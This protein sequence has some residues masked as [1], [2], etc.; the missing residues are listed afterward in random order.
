MREMPD[1]HRFSAGERLMNRYRILGELGR[2]GMGVVYKCLDEIGG[3]EVALKA[4]PLELG[5]NAAE[6]EEVREN[7]QLVSRLVHQHIAAIKTLE[8][9][10][11]S[12]DYYLILE[13]AEGAD[14]RRWRKQQGG[15]PS[16]D[17]SIP[18]LRQV[19]QALDYAH[20]LKIIHRDVKPGNVMITP[21]GVV[22]VLDFG[23]AAQIQSSMA[24]VSRVHFSTSGTGPY[25]SPEQW[26]G[27][28]QDGASD[29]Y[30]LAVMAFELLAG[31]LPFE[32]Q[33]QF[34]LRESAIRETP[35]RPEG[36]SDQVWLA[37]A[38][39]L[40]KNST[41]RFTSCV[42]FVAALESG[43]AES[44]LTA[45]SRLVPGQWRTPAFYLPAGIV[46]VLLLLAG[47]WI[48]K[49]DRPPKNPVVALMPAKPV[50]SGAAAAA[51]EEKTRAEAQVKAREA[52]ARD[53]AEAEARAR[54]ADAQAKTEAE[55]NAR[56]R[57]AVEKLQAEADARARAEARAR[58]EAIAQA[59]AVGRLVVVTDPDG[60][61]VALGSGEK[62]ES[63]A[64]FE[65]LP[66]GKIALNISKDGYEP[67]T[68]TVEIK[69]NQT[70]MPGKITLIRLEGTV[71]ITSQP[72]GA[73]VIQDGKVIGLTPFTLD[74]VPAGE[75]VY[76][77]KLA[78]F[79]DSVVRGA[80]IANRELELVQKLEPGYPDLQNP[81]T[82]S[83]GMVLL[84]VSSKLLFAKW[85]VR[86]QDYQAYYRENSGINLAWQKPGFA[87]G[88]THPVVRVSW[89]DA[90]QFCAWLTRKERR[91]GFIS[92][93]QTYRLP[94]DAEWSTAAGLNE[95]QSGTPREKDCQI[96]GVYPWG[97]R[98]PPPNGV[99]NYRES[100]RVDIHLK[101]SPVGCFPANQFGL[102]DMG[103]NVWQWCADFFDGNLSSHPLRGASWKDGASDRPLLSYRH[104]AGPG[105][106][107]NH[108]GFRCVL[109]EE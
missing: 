35:Q 83:I 25:M 74:H 37:L 80:V 77:L 27:Q 95:P 70:L 107:D 4:L 73:S 85:D 82:N 38:R 68:L 103:G 57:E 101:T 93:R 33:D 30:A 13:L 24:R 89:D 71:K 66:P 64:C 69:P 40:N 2:G 20:G 55:N 56:T 104:A 46:L 106:R 31:H 1:P 42:E 16:P 17:R 7:F 43:F 52:D 23:L 102:C 105:T 94:K 11:H 15:C 81:Y 41:K 84:P 18:V 34:A 59:N 12:G 63:P 62:L 29:Q 26:R 90:N 61:K 50:A 49:R 79:T 36:L 21:D 87:Q 14:L 51:A 48:L 88:D 6:M 47:G 39:G 3:I 44:S 67:S 72:A 28:R 98:W 5:R 78:R 54:A 9:D 22:K 19:A 65:Q 100:L 96:K 108:A 91:D 75:V 60:A 76:H 109:C 99:G 86:V 10:P 32:T 53:R 58:D 92:P 97:N 45:A 8:R